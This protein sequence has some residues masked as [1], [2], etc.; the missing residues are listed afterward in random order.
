MA[1]VNEKRPR[2]KR[3]EKPKKR[4]KKDSSVNDPIILSDD[5]END[6]DKGSIDVL[7]RSWTTSCQKK[8]DES[9]AE[10]LPC[11][12]CGI[13][14]EGILRLLDL[15]PPHLPHDLPFSEKS[16]DA[17]ELKMY[18]CGIHDHF[19][20]PFS[21]AT[22]FS[23]IKEKLGKE[24]ENQACNKCGIHKMYVLVLLGLSRSYLT[25][26]DSLLDKFIGGE[27]D[28]RSDGNNTTDEETHAFML[29]MLLSGITDFVENPGG[30]DDHSS[31]DDD[32]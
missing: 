22:R 5:D 21:T 4:S 17:L 16:M 3:T 25:K 23:A 11:E 6:E 9:N 7:S 28:K 30:T 12:E 10:K 13:T 14:K 26:D 15:L 29:S 8:V 18:L 2:S 1:T 27:N 20:N 24:T 32:K 19:L 31:E